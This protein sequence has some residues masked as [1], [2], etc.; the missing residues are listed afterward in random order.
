MAKA[1]LKGL[2]DMAFEARK[3]ETAR[4]PSKIDR[5]SAFT[6]KAVGVEKAKPIKLEATVKVNDKRAQYLAPMEFGE[7]VDLH[8]SGKT[9][10][11]GRD[12]IVIPVANAI[13]NALGSA[14]RNAVARALR[15]PRTFL[16]RVHNQHGQQQYGGVWQRQG[17]KRL[18]IEPILFFR[19]HLEYEPVLDFREDV[20]N[21]VRLKLNGY[22]MRRLTQELSRTVH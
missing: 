8:G 12:A 22:I 6:R 5:P 9:R 15:L 4:L 21:D 14:G 7:D 18:P 20:T 3:S 10:G 17:D 13:K 11:S 2:N 1:A 16:M 19:K